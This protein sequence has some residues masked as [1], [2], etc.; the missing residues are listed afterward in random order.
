M[1]SYDPDVYFSLYISFTIGSGPIVIEYFM[2]MQGC[3]LH[4][5]PVE[6]IM[7][8]FQIRI[9]LQKGLLKVLVAGYL[10]QYCKIMC[11]Y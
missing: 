1:L 4:K 8:V 5:L 10:I 11:H 2:D 9:P 7:H 3:S 6:Y